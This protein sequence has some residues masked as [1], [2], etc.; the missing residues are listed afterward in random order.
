MSFRTL[1]GVGD[2]LD[3]LVYALEPP[4][5]I[6]EFYVRPLRCF[7]QRCQGNRLV[8]GGAHHYTLLCTKCYTVYG[9]VEP[10]RSADTM[11]VSGWRGEQDAN[12][13]I[14]CWMHDTLESWFPTIYQWCFEC[15][16]VYRTAEDLEN[17]YAEAVKEIKKHRG[18]E[19]LE[20]TKPADKIYFCQHCLHDF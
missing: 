19:H 14:Y 20:D 5:E 16:H 7:R 9:P 3:E 12:A 18:F 6:A 15:R 4:I 8:P 11:P 2:A 10:F 1:S 13:K 17:D